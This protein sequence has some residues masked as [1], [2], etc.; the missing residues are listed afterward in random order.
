MDA[1]DGQALIIFRL[2][3]VIPRPERNR[4]GRIVLLNSCP[5]KFPNYRG[6]LLNEFFGGEH[7]R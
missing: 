1:F 2:A 6:D 3:N 7:N 4:K 5:P